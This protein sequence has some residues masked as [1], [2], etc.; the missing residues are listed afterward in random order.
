[1]QVGD[2]HGERDTE[3]GIDD[4]VLLPPAPSA[5]RI[6]VDAQAPSRV[7]HAVTGLGFGLRLQDTGA[8]S[9]GGR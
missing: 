9:G 5:R 6:Q 2:V 7:V 3:M 1:M 8:A 4:T